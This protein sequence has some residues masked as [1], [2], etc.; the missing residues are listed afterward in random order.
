MKLFRELWIYIPL[1]IVSNAVTAQVGIITTVAGTGTSGYSGDGGLAIHA[2]LS[3]PTDLAIDSRNNIYIADGNNNRIRKIDSAGIITTIA[4]N[5]IAG[6]NGDNI[7]ATSAELNYPAGIAVDSKDNIY[8][9]DLYNNRVRKVDTSSGKIITIAGN[10]ISGYKGDGGPADSAELNKPCNVT[11]DGSG[12]IYITDA[13]NNVIRKVDNLSGFISTIIGDS[14]MGYSGDGGLATSAE[15][16]NPGGLSLDAFHNIYLADFGNQRIRK[17]SAVTVNITTIAGNG[18]AGY[19]GDGW[20]ALVSSLWGPNNVKL[21][22]IGNYYI[23]DYYN[24]RIRKVDTTGII[25]TI[26]GNGTAGYSGNGGNATSAELNGPTS[27]AFD[28]YGNIYIA[29]WANN[30]IREVSTITAVNNLGRNRYFTVY[31]NPT[32]DIVNISINNINSNRINIQICDLTGEV[33]LQKTINTSE[34]SITTT[35]NIEKF[36]TG[37]YFVYIQI[38]E[39]QFISNLVKL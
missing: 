26:V 12:N 32:K 27:L 6:F 23:A 4:G 1:I 14:I 34:P 25:T 5:G 24:N 3:Y 31:P 8:I 37:L 9:C 28:T 36:S 30:V 10:G 2:K 16:N 19:S 39:E 15:I 17:V 20:Y 38:G 11:V 7:P 13:G 35:V 22:S 18:M 29:D 33:L 21:D